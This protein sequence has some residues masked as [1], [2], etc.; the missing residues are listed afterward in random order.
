MDLTG[1]EAGR[2]KKIQT[3]SR[4]TRPTWLMG[5][6]FPGRHQG[7]TEE[8]PFFLT[9]SIGMSEFDMVSKQDV[10]VKKY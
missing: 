4:A 5:I 6:Q 10:D 1:R 8:C 3:K 9:S 7:H 2:G